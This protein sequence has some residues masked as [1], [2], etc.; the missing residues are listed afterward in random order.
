MKVYVKRHAQQDARLAAFAHDIKTPLCCV[1][2][3]A[4]MAMAA[5]RQ[6]KDISRQME[7]ILLA[8]GVM[9]RMLS[10]LS[11]GE[12]AP[13]RAGFTRD[14]LTR[15]LLAMTAEAARQKDQVLSVD[16]LA[17]GEGM[18]WTDF[19]AL[20]RI[21]TNLLQNA[22]KYTPTGGL[23]TLC[24]QR[25]EGNVMRF[26]VRDNGMGMKPAFL[27]RLF[28]PFARAQESAH[29][30]GR[31]LGLSIAKELTRQLGGTIE[32]ESA[33]GRGTT[34]TVCVPLDALGGGGN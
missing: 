5:G 14:M 32:V 29:L 27:K 30:P 23:I 16:L 13:R 6:G 33:W 25:G 19:A 26:I 31:G 21:L 24:A 8:V 3:A 22:V 20:S 15:E 28:T 4:Q 1:S 9:D 12:K 34:F 7:Q 11:A 10:Q 17:L 2:G 18:Y